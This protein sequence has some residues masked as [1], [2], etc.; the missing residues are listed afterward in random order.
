MDDPVLIKLKADAAVLLSDLWRT[1]RN[2]PPLEDEERRYGLVDP[3][4]REKIPLEN[5]GGGPK[6][7]GLCYF[8]LN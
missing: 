6:H 5:R 2:Q 8:H 1:I 4:G 3:A 7:G